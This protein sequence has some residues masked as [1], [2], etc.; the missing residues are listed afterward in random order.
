MTMKRIK[1]VIVEEV[2][3]EVEH[4]KGE[5]TKFVDPSVEEIRTGSSTSQ[6][7]A[8]VAACER[9]DRIEI[10]MARD[11]GTAWLLAV[12]SLQFQQRCQRHLATC[13]DL[14]VLAPLSS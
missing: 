5:A 8:C 1:M 4:R 9:P 2:V 13:I 3:P 12:P 10:E 11:S 7:A 14:Q 6:S